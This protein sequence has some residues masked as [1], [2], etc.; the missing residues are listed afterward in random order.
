[1]NAI[2]ALWSR[3][4]LTVAVKLFGDFNLLCLKLDFFSFSRRRFR[5]LLSLILISRK[6]KKGRFLF[7]IIIYYY[8]IIIYYCFII[9][10]KEIKKASIRSI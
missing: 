8:I 1:M 5:S 7:I 6:R 10:K 3:C 4:Y 2:R 9:I